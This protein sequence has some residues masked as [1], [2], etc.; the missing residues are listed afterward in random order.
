MKRN[1]LLILSLFVI[2]FSC[3]KEKEYH[4][5]THV[6]KITNSGITEFDEHITFNVTPGTIG[7][8]FID[9][10]LPE[11]P[12]YLKDINGN[13]YIS[14]TAPSKNLGKINI[15][16]DKGS[17][18]LNTSDFA[19]VNEA[20]KS[21]LLRFNI[22]GS[23]NDFYHVTFTM[24][25]ALNVLAPVKN[26]A[27]AELTVSASVTPVGPV[28]GIILS[29]ESKVGNGSYSSILFTDN[30]HVFAAGTFNS[31]DNVYVRF[32]ASKGNIKVQKEVKISIE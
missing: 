5:E 4:D 1:N 27:G 29:A 9:V 18:V 23:N 12:I 22:N 26:S 13:N 16:G 28:S 14:S 17:I 32:T 2:L 8:N 11:T 19:W 20:Q 7:V 10:Y 15:E 24:S 3:V 25:S 6:L 21:Q 30:K 31:G